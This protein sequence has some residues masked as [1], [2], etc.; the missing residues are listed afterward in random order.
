MCFRLKLFFSVILVMIVIVC[1][2]IQ[3]SML[4]D[5]CNLRRL[6][7]RLTTSTVAPADNQHQMELADMNAENPS[8][9]NSFQS[10][11][12]IIITNCFLTYTALLIWFSVNIFLVTI[13]GNKKTRT[14]RSFISLFLYAAIPLF[15]IYKNEKIQEYVKLCYN[16]LSLSH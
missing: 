1:L 2:L 14:F 7:K 6:L 12:Y 16:K 4:V 3:M 5:I 8:N 9:Y 13:F 15:R 11:D 10:K